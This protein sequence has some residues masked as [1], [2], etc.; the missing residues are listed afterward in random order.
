MAKERK[1]F[2]VYLKDGA[3]HQSRLYAGFYF[4]VQG[5]RHRFVVVDNAHGIGQNVTHAASGMKVCALGVGANYLRGYAKLN[6]TAY[7]E[8]AKMSLQELID[9]VGEA[10]VRT[11]LAAAPDLK[12]EVAKP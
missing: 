8:R 6:E 12:K 11:V 9:R 7:V 1:T 5:E 2:D 4:V 10:K 3:T